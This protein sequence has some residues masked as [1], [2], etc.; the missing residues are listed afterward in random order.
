MANLLGVRPG[1]V[2]LVTGARFTG[3][4]AAALTALSNRVLVISVVPHRERCWTAV[5]VLEWGG[6]RQ[7]WTRANKG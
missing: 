1:W 6:A 3:E 7:L 2:S 4:L 5:P